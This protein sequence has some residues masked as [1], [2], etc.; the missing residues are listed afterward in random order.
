MLV[1]PLT[2]PDDQLIGIDPPKRG[3]RHDE[4]ILDAIVSG[5]D[6]QLADITGRERR[7]W[8]N[9]GSDRWHRASRRARSGARYATRL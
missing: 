1:R 4:A 3:E 7:P 8:L 5:D 2:D 9:K 6:E